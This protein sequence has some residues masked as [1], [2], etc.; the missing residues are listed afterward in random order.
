MP[1]AKPEVYEPRCGDTVRIPNGDKLLVAYADKDT[2]T[3]TWF[4]WPDGSIR[5]SECEVIEKCD[6]E[7][8]ARCVKEWFDAQPS[9]VDRGVRSTNRRRRRVLEKYGAALGLQDPPPPWELSPAKAEA[10]LRE[11]EA[12][13]R[14]QAEVWWG[15]SGDYE[16]AQYHHVQCNKIRA[17]LGME[18]LNEPETDAVRMGDVEQPDP[19]S[20]WSRV[21]PEATGILSE[22]E[23]L[24]F[25][26][27]MSA[28]EYKPNKPSM[29]LLATAFAYRSESSTL[30]IRLAH[31]KTLF[32]KLKA[33][34]DA[35]N[36]M[37]P[38]IQE[39][40][41][42]QAPPQVFLDAVEEMVK[43][44]VKER[45][46]LVGAMNVWLGVFGNTDAP[47][48]G[49]PLLGLFDI[50][51]GYCIGVTADPLLPDGEVHECDPFSAEVGIGLMLGALYKK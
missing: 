39:G 50:G 49:G 40:L 8:H 36:W 41:D 30:A 16:Q 6:D 19:E 11:L 25:E 21:D 5:L 38:L 3:L 51:D 9:H 24:E 33:G 48:S 26:R 17:V 28:R 37:A 34:N 43:R 31:T 44:P 29:R 15:E 27:V 20:T 32:E 42:V 12:E 22:E 35:G 45:K 14:E 7:K 13:H 18:P 23:L 4:G 47:A 10:L 1:E 46:P 2:D